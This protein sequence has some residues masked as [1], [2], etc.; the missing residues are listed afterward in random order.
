MSLD[1]D[2]SNSE[3]SDWNDFQSNGIYPIEHFRVYGYPLIAELAHGK[4]TM[5]CSAIFIYSKFYE[6]MESKV[7]SRLVDIAEK[8][9]KFESCDKISL[10]D[11][12]CC[13]E[14]AFAKLTPNI[15][16]KLR[17]KDK[18]V[19]DFVREKTPARNIHLSRRNYYLSISYGVLP[20]H[21][22]ENNRDSGEIKSS[23]WYDV[24]LSD[25][26]IGEMGFGGDYCIR[27]TLEDF[28]LPDKDVIDFLIDNYSVLTAPLYISSLNYSEET[29]SFILDHCY[30]LFQ[31]LDCLRKI[32]DIS[33]EVLDQAAIQ[34]VFALSEKES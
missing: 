30:D 2:F 11:C 25:E 31:N 1:W 18:K 19:I 23:K 21:L 17:Y 24:A 10:D 9:K 13:L 33:E 14:G 32:E 5:R 6:P 7:V 26:K 34:S 22:I 15:R 29:V 16:R 8:F 28:C 20:R 4:S 27:L 3:G 12:S